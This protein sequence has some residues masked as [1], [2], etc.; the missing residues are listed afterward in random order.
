MHRF[1]RKIT[2]TINGQLH[3]LTPPPL[4]RVSES[5]AENWEGEPGVSRSFIH[6]FVRF[7]GL[8]GTQKTVST[9]F[10][11]PPLKCWPQVKLGLGGEL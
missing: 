1:G 10:W 5:Q 2:F 6:T 4:M 9:K 11:R 7:W 8:P 3:Y